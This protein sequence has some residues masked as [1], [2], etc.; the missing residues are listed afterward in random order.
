MVGG[1]VGAVGRVLLGGGSVGA[2]MTQRGQKIVDVVNQAINEGVT[3]A[4]CWAWVEQI[5]VRA[6]LYQPPEKFYNAFEYIFRGSQYDS[7]SPQKFLPTSQY[8]LV[9]VGDWLYIHNKNQWDANGNHSVIFLG[10]QN[11]D[12]GVA[13]VASTPFAN[14]PGKIETR[15]LIE[16]PIAF[17]MRA[18]RV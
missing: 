10:W 16:Q 5:F 12:S 4:H 6:G 9:Q 3:A 17:V 15:N 2:S 1:L 13:T 8:G 18:R 14:K 7:S 11:Q